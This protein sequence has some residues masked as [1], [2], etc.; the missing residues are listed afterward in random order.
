MNA[1]TQ[2]RPIIVARRSDDNILRSS[3]IHRTAKKMVDRVP[4]PQQSEALVQRC[5]VTSGFK[6]SLE[7]VETF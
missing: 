6:Q 1:G 3:P 5:K 4:K 7:V 2:L